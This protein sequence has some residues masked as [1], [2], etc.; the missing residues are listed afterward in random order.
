MTYQPFPD[1]GKPNGEGFILMKEI[2]SKFTKSIAPI[3]TIILPIPTYHYYVDGAKPIYKKFFNYFNNPEKNIY[4]LDLLKEFENL[5]FSK[6][7]SLCFSQ[8]KSHFSKFG[9]QAIS[10]FLINQIN[11]RKILPIPK[12][13]RNIDKSSLSIKNNT[14]ILGVSAFYH[15]SA[16]TLIKDGEIVAA[17]QEER[18]SRVKND[19]RF[20]ISAIN[21]CLEKANIHQTDL[22]A[23]VYYDNASL[24]LERILWS[25]LK[26]APYSKDAWL[27]TMP[28]WVRYKLFLPQLIRKKL[29]YNGK[30]F[31][32]LHHRSHIAAA[33]FPSPFKKAA[34]LTVD[35]VGEWATA[36]IAIGDKNKISIIKEMNF[37]N[38]L[39]LL[40][41]A[42]T[43]FIGFKVNSG[44]YKMMGLAPYGK[45]NLR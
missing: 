14:Y 9:N 11:N 35:G 7:K 39:G 8:D 4:V 37:P 28:S 29:K 10:D 24:T 36:S 43:Q 3:P 34:I 32:D 31:H 1:Y 38:S 19:R 22:K 30:I 5:N 18:F 26:T 6:R 20:P 21:F 45:T 15:D 12:S 41:S 16:A 17:A 25:F 33:F 13:I 44:E 2:L 42:F 27:R 23:I 40:Y